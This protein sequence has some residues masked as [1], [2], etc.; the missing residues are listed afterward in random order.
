LARQITF[1]AGQKNNPEKDTLQI[2]N[3]FFFGGELLHKMRW[4]EWSELNF[5]QK[6]K[7]K[8]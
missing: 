7:I 8:N 6:M 2:G 5:G 4:A 3:L 1:P